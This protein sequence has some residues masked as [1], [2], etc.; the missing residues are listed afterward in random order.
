MPRL[1]MCGQFLPNKFLVWM[2]GNCHKIGCGMWLAR[3]IIIEGIV[4]TKIPHN[5]KGCSLDCLRKKKI[6]ILLSLNIH[7]PEIEYR[8][9]QWKLS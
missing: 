4:Q 8:V 1:W 5:Q 3:K 7:Y 9:S 2:W 6:I